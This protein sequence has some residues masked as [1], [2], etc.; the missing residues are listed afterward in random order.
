MYEDFKKV[1]QVAMVVKDAEAKAKV[2]AQIFGVDVPEGRW[3]EPYDTAH[4]TFNGEPTEAR[5]KLVF[6]EMENLQIELIQPDGKPSTWQQYLDKHGE[7]IHHI[8]FF[9]KDMEGELTRLG[10]IGMNL[11]QRGQYTGGEYAYLNGG[12]LLPC[13]F[14]LLADR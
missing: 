8:A 9:V 12:E 7:G 1:T 3:T 10:E 4:T 13:I 14:E 5:S 6:F 2:F 11:E